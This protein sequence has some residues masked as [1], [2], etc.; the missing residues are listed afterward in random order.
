MMKSF[1]DFFAAMWFNEN[2][3]Q[4]RVTGF[5]NKGKKKNRIINTS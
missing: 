1:S 3:S 5:G 4:S 2:S